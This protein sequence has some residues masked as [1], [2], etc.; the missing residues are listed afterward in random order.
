[1]FMIVERVFWN[2]YIF[3]AMGSFVSEIGKV[4]HLGKTLFRNLEFFWKRKLSMQI[5][6][7]LKITQLRTLSENDMFHI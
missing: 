1:M 5:L 4:A 2:A 7:P 3:S 6:V